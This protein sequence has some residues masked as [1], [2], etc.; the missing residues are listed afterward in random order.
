MKQHG[1]GTIPVELL[2]LDGP[3]QLWK[4]TRLGELCDVDVKSIAACGL[5]EGPEKKGVRNTE[6]RLLKAI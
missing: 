3:R 1:D 5:S 6:C 2:I 4:G